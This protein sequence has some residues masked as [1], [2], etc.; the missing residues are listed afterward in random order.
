MELWD[1]YDEYRI[2]TGKT[3][4]R[5]E[6]MN[7]GDYHIAVHVWV[8]NSK[9]QFLLQKRHEEK[10][11][12]PGMWECSAAGSAIAGDDSISAAI[13]E[14]KEEIGLDGD[15]E[16]F[17]FLYSVK[18]E[19]G[20][21]DIYIYRDDVDIEK[22]VLQPEEV[23]D[24]KWAYPDEIAKMISDGVFIP[25]KYLG[26]LFESAK[27]PVML[28]SAKREDAVKLYE[29]QKEVFKPLYDRYQDHE[30]SPYTQSFGKFMLKFERGDGYEIHY[31][32]DIAGC[33]FIYPR[34]EK[35]MYFYIIYIKDAFHNKGIAQYVMERLELMYPQ[36][37]VWELT[38]ILEE[39]KNC[40]LYEKMGYKKTGETRYINDNMNL[41]EYH[42]TDGI[43]RI[44][45]L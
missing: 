39:E 41:V 31:G 23:T 32:E 42:K 28:K 24:V 40:Y 2:P 10:I 16:R 12:F 7:K 5:G 25:F 20:F 34:D 36:Y 15:I 35:T 13:R 27:S 6:K 30:F 43:Q 8:I 9:G 22:L 38:T 45:R 44:I 19:N 18:F 21:D 17:E 33:V 4:V 3:H 37:Q 1:L 14:M 26:R 29:L 11:G